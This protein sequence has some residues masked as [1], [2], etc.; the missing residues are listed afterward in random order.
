MKK[1]LAIFSLTCCKGCLNEGIYSASAFRSILELYEII[2]GSKIKDDWQ[3][4]NIAL[5]EGT[6]DDEQAVKLLRQIRKHCD[7]AIAIG[8][9][10]NLGGVQSERNLMPKKLIDEDEVRPISDII[11][12]DYTIPGCP[13]SPDELRQCLVDL[14]W[15][16]K[17][18]LPDL[19]VCFECRQKNNGCFLEKQKPCLGPITR[20]GCHSTCI[21]HGQSCYGCRGNIADPNIDKLKEILSNFADKD[22]IENLLTFYGKSK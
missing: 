15:N 2:D 22:Q 9:C 12:V 13:I 10:A 16:K 14:Y 7:I 5:I 17:F 18:T 3:R 8:S 4:Y 6:P 21:D 19:P 20:M 1:T 11:R